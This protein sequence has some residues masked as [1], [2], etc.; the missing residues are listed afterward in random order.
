MLRISKS[1]PAPGQVAIR[2][3]GEV[4]NGWVEAL[5]SACLSERADGER[6]TI[7]LEGVRFVD[8]HGVALIR[9]LSDRHHVGL[10]NGTPFIMAL[11]RGVE[12]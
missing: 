6:V 1:R 11:L 12:K 7:D 9:D 10:E 5:K 3:E 2:L 8:R 4:R